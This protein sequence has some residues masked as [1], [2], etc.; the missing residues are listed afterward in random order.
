M[1]QLPS[2]LSPSDA[3]ALARGIQPSWH[4]FFGEPPKAP[5]MALAAT[6]EM[7]AALDIEDE[8]TKELPKR[9][10]VSAPPA[11][12]SPPQQRPARPDKRQRE[13]ARA[14][15][16]APV[17]ADP[18]HLPTSSTPWG[19][20]LGGLAAL[21]A[22]A[23]GFVMFT[24]SDDAP[25][26]TATDNDRAAQAPEPKKT[27]AP[28]KPAPSPVNAAKNE[29]EP[30][31]PEPAEPE[32]AEPE[33]ETEDPEPETEPEPVA[34]APDP[35]PKATPPRR[36][37]PRTGGPFPRTRPKPKSKPGGIVRDAPF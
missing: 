32:P 11:R 21:A 5:P 24:G 17:A 20:I 36:P 9:A 10:A 15:P 7:P 8:Q 28:E 27:A 31:E 34:A 35:A 30:A 26:E 18:V 12:R 22:V 1:T 29:P 2:G 19:M 23:V 3:D 25:A 37:P 16:A 14:Q 4:D 13:P 6:A 33:P